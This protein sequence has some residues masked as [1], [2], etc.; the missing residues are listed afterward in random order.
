MTIDPRLTRGPFLDVVTHVSEI[1][2]LEPSPTQGAHSHSTS[3]RPAS[4]SCRCSTP[5][6]TEWAHHD[7]VEPGL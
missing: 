5:E 4:R 6:S 1:V 7:I 3:P 2:C